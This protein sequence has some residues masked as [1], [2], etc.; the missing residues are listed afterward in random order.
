MEWT[1]NILNI[2]KFRIYPKKFCYLKRN[3]LTIHI[4]HPVYIPPPISSMIDLE[5]W[6]STAFPSPSIRVEEKTIVF[7]F[8]KQARI[9]KNL[10]TYKCGSAGE[11][12]LPE[13]WPHWCVTAPFCS[14]EG[15]KR[16]RNT[17]MRI[18]LKALLLGLSRIVIFS[19]S[20]N[21]PW[22]KKH[23]EFTTCIFN[24]LISPRIY[25]S[26]WFSNSQL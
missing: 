18:H 21:K 1:H 23:K 24:G 12:L 19:I 8:R 4:A 20:N 6:T 10:G 2:T 9:Y 16:Q 14:Q 17:S 25:T 7:C 22:L 26:I 11:K 5:I 3:S 15:F 13:H